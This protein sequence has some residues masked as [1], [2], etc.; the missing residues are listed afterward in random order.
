MIVARPAR[1]V[2]RVMMVDVGVNVRLLGG[3]RD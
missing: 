2:Y 1:V 3:W